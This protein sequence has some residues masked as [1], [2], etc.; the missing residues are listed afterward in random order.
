MKLAAWVVT[1]LAAASATAFAAEDKA[2]AACRKQEADARTK[3]AAEIAKAAK[4]LVGMKAFDEAHAALRVAL[5]V[6]PDDAACRKDFAA[7]PWTYRA[8]PE[9]AAKKAAPL[10]EASDK[11]CRGHLSSALAAWGKAER[12]EDYAR[13]ATT[14][15]AFFDPAGQTA[16]SLQLAWYEP[17]LAWAR[18]KD[19]ER[20]EKGDEFVDGAWVEAAG[21]KALDA[22]HADW[23][24]P[25]VLGDGFHEVRTT[26]PLRAG[27][28]VQEYVRSWRRFV[29]DYFAGEWDWKQPKGPL[30]VYLTATQDDY[31][32]RL[33]E[34]DPGAVRSK[35]SALYVQKTGGLCPVFVTFQP[36]DADGATID[37]PALLRDL[38]HE[39]AHQILYES[40]MA[41]GA[42][43]GGNI[44]WVS[45][46]AANFLA[47]HEPAQGRWKM[48]S[49]EQEPY[50]SGHEPGAF[51][52]TKAHFNEVP[53]LSKY[54]AASEPNL[55]T[56]QEYWIAT[57][58]TRFLLA[59]AD[60]RYRNQFVNMLLEVHMGRGG[61]GTFAKCFGKP[62]FG[63]MQE[64][65]KAFVEGIVVEKE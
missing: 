49:R 9:A 47:V 16:E 40:C 22:A 30:P 44:D 14:L 50:L 17:Y 65:W 59:G 10:L 36:K 48:T 5:Q 2:V 41:Q 45:E 64:Q 35:A 34:F 18:K 32:A 7:L 61:A 25:W 37:W 21:V 55:D 53:E 42:P 62:D 52:W 15:V 39:T 24:T 3:C 57:T 63:Q 28:R 43:V 4:S 46:G 26:M 19:A 6:A 54:L 51:A 1:L 33:A 31:Q 38:R 8:T 27:K 58:L 20:W 12:P 56:V 11:A 13:L 23:K 29:L 60:R